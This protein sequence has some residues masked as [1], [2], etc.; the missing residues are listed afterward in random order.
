MFLGACAGFCYPGAPP[1]AR[2]PSSTAAPAAAA[3]PDTIVDGQGRVEYIVTLDCAATLGLPRRAVTDGRFEAYH[4]PQA[5]HLVRAVE[6]DHGVVATAMT[7]IVA[8]PFT[9]F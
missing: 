9:A 7:S 2:S 6:R 1:D 5:G 3:A 8:I 4:A